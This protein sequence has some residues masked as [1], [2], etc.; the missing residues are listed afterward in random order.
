MQR[1]RDIYD[2]KMVL[3]R[4]HAANQRLW[5]RDG[6]SR[7]PNR[8]SASTPLIEAEHQAL[9]DFL[10]SPPDKHSHY[11]LSTAA[12][13]CKK[14]KLILTARRTSYVVWRKESA[15]DSWAL[16]RRRGMATV[17]R[18]QILRLTVSLVIRSWSQTLPRRQSFY[19]RGLDRPL[20]TA[21]AVAWLSSFWLKHKGDNHG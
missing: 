7:W 9:L 20:S 4:L 16:S 11:A 10:T 21:N 5:I 14:G 19:S 18:S 12:G 2:Q 1:V 13:I 8:K 6:Q 17:F 15:P 3:A